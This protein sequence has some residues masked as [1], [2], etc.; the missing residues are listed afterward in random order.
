VYGAGER[1]DGVGDG[2]LF[3][4]AGSYEGC[5]ENRVVVEGG[6]NPIS[7]RVGLV[8]EFS[9]QGKR[10]LRKTHLAESEC[11]KVLHLIGV[12]QATLPA[13][14]IHY[15]LPALELENLCPERS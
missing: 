12:D 4:R 8:F 10:G 13:G 6:F 15:F 2:E 7:L 3:N 11:S 5:P 14:I 1:G 9:S